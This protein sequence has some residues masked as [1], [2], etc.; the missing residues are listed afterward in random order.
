MHPCGDLAGLF[1]PWNFGGA[2]SGSRDIGKTPDARSAFFLSRQIRRKLP[3][4]PQAFFKGRPGRALPCVSQGNRVG[5]DRIDRFSR[6]KQ[7][8]DG[9]HLQSLSSRSWGPRS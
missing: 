8:D 1:L 2:S 7:I 9:R 4:L 6:Q 5:Q 3:E